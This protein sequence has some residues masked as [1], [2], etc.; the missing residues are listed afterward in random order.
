MYAA[1]QR[2]SPFRQSCHFK[3][4]RYCLEKLAVLEIKIG[5]VLNSFDNDVQC[6]ISH[7]KEKKS[8]ESMPDAN[9]SLII[10][11]PEE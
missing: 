9:E 1:Q 2:T 10:I 7:L 5:N 11:A 4:N 6:F 3:I 8:N